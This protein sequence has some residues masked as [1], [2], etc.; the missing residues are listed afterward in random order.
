M[1]RLNPKFSARHF[2]QGQA[3]RDA[4][5]RRLFGEHLVMSGLPE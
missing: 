3:F 4:E 2:A 5:K 1:R